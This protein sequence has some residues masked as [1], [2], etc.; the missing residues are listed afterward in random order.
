MP[1]HG[2]RKR[3]SKSGSSARRQRHRS[4]SSSKSGG[5]KRRRKL[6][7]DLAAA[8]MPEDASSKDASS[9]DASSKSERQR[10]STSASREKK[11]RSK[12]EKESS[13]SDKCRRE[14]ARSRSCKERREK[15][16]SFKILREAPREKERSRSGKDRKARGR[17]RSRDR[18]RSP[19]RKSDKKASKSKRRDRT[20]TED[21]KTSKSLAPKVRE[22]SASKVREKSASKVG[23]KE[24]GQKAEEKGKESQETG[25]KTADGTE[26]GKPLENGGHTDAEAEPAAKLAVKAGGAANLLGDLA[27]LQKGLERERSILQLFILKAKQE[28]DEQKESKDKKAM[29]EK[30]Y[31]KGFFGEPCGP[32]DQLILEEE[33]GRGVFST[34]FRAKDIGHSGKEFAV[35][36]IRSNPMLKKATEKEIR[37]MRRLR[38]EASVKDPDGARCFLGLA[39]PETFE[40]K[41]HLALVFHLQRCD[42]RTGLQKYGQGRGLPL[43]LVRSYAKDLFMAL[44]ALGAVNVIHSDVKPDNLLM[45]LDKASVRLSD[46]GSAMAVTERVR[47]DY[48]QPRFYR[49]P[50]VILGQSY[51][52]QIDVWSAASTIFE[53]ATGR[54]L[55]TGKTN[56]GMIHEMLKICGAFSKSFATHGETAKKHFTKAGDFRCKEP[57]GEEQLLPASHF[58]K[59]LTPLSKLL[60]DVAASPPA[61]VDVGVQKLLAR[62]LC[63]LLAQAL[64]P[65]PAERATPEQALEHKYFQ[66]MGGASP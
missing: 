62:L 45:S 59:P 27:E 19:S 65:D 51:T 55:F 43:F 54:I 44:R 66:K 60:A 41:G 64:V 24:V 16:K 35:K 11:H 1:K 61:G 58:K 36:F 23:E 53:L 34:V 15:S 6:A 14:K 4:S 3:A 29:R 38:N 57:G 42:M 31:F 13:T 12:K 48:L 30:E 63:E 40:Y 7:Q 49:A 56:N 21:A 25:K 10:S 20:S 39:G 22:E 33:L 50:E 28:H 18:E 52:T 2:S 17:S 5:A 47:T 37:L 9:K 32:L 26:S 46:F 8:F